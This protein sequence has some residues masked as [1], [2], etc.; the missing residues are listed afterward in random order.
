MATTQ[1]S[2]P[3]GTHAI[4]MTRAFNAPRELLFRA[5][6]DPELLAQWLGPRGLTMTVD[7]FDVRDGGRWRYIERGPEGSEDAFHG[8]FHG[9]PSPE[10]GIVQTFEYEGMPGHVALQK[11]TFEERGSTTLLRMSSIF[12]S[13]EDRDGMI[14]SGMESG[15][16]DSMERLEE[17]LARLAPAH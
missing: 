14:A 7:T 11:A 6:T 5:H 13:I 15:A 4:E 2:A 3:P 17:L 1:I 16:N 12:Q 8:I 9:T 10:A